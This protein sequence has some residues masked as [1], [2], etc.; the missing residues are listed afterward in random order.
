MQNIE[1]MEKVTETQARP[2]TWSPHPSEWSNEDGDENDKDDQARAPIAKPILQG[3][4]PVL[5]LAPNP[6]QLT[7][8]SDFW[9][10]KYCSPC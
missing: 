1:K 10:R 9:I 4:N 8:S 7:E 5:H 6:V 3:P 2:P